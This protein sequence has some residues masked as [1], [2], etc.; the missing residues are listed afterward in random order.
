MN[1]LQPT[2]TKFSGDLKARIKEK[3]KL[4]EKL[5]QNI[6]PEHI[7]DYLGARINLDTIA[8]AKLV[9]SD[10]NKKVKIIHV[11]DFLDDVA[12][13]NKGSEY[14]AIHAQVLTKDGYSFELQIRLKELEKL[15]DESHV[16]YKKLK[17]QKDT[18]SAKELA[19]LIKADEKIK[20]KL[21]AKYFQI[22]DKEFSR[23]NP[24]NDIDTPIVIGQR[25]DDATGEIIP[26]T[27]TAREMFEEDGK[28]ATMFERLRDCV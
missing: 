22:K 14:R 10:L 27:K 7:S 11:D 12:R 2:A 3:A 6:K 19:D 16:I 17:W 13:S 23:L 24:T 21:K 20:K 28:S 4:Q 15:T 25:L 9:L 1:D 8:Q 5:D 18:L 26:L